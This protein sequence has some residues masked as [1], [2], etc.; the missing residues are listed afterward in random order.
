V[1]RAVAERTGMMGDVTSDR[2]PMSSARVTGWGAALPEKVVTNVDLESTLDTSDAWIVERTG[3]RERRI[4]GTTA[5]LGIDAARVAMDRASVS[6]ADIDL[7]LLCTSTP[8]EAMPA[9]ASVIQHELGVRG[10]AVDLNAACSGF[11]YGLVAADGFLRAGLRRV[12]L[13][14]AETMSRIVDWDDRGTAI[15]FGDGAGAVVL[16]RGDG[17]G[18]VLG[19]DLGSDGSLRH[20]LHADTAGTIEMDGPEVFRRAVR[21][22]VDSAEAALAAAG[23]TA[24]DVTLFIPHQANARI[25]TSACARLGI[26]DDRTLNILATTGNTSAASIPMALAGAAD[27]GRLRPGDLVLMT[28]F[29]AGMS[30]ASAVLEWAT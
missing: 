2:P 26:G 8:D 20:I 13:V 24:D 30:W 28:G 7:V 25:I 16:E 15:L 22:V 12:L 5:G 10:G 14:G 4:G 18:R 23:I 1:T 9:G 19:F 3:I 27:D 11:V 6:G 17:P 29:G 21:V